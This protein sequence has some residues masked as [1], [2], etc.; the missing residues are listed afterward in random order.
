[1][2][3]LPGGGVIPAD[4]G[5]ALLIAPVSAAACATSRV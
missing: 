4:P 5:T 1:M 2:D 3:A